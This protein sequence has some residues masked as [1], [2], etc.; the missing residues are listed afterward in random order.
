MITSPE[1]QKVTFVELFFD[2]V[3]VFSV[4][5]IVKILNEGQD[6]IA[7]GQSILIFWL[8]WRTWSQ[9]TWSVNAAYTTHPLVELSVLIGTGV[10]LFGPRRSRKPSETAPS[11]LPPRTR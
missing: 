5:P 9:L 6:W 1:D 4:T 11:C 3:L 8:V 2:L 7:V 10:A